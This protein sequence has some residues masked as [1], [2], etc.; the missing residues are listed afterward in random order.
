MLSG[1]AASSDSC[2]PPCTWSR[3]EFIGPHCSAEWNSTPSPC[4]S[5]LITWTYEQYLFV[6]SFVC[7][8]TVIM[9]RRATE[10]DPSHPSE[11]QST[12]QQRTPP[13]DR[14][15]VACATL[16]PNVFISQV[17]L[18]RPQWCAA[19]TMSQYREAHHGCVLP[20]QYANT[21]DASIYTHAYIIY[22]YIHLIIYI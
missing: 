2:F 4:V 20:V 11:L 13:R 17:C 9:G 10:L 16:P 18:V 1:K 8:E 7:C 6:L 19:Q 22:N 14:L 12:L 21:R 3:L 15:L 5:L